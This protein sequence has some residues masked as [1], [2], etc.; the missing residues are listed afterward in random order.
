MI[1]I[2]VICEMAILAL[3]G[4]SAF[5]NVCSGC[6]FAPLHGLSVPVLALL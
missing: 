4:N 1:V 3:R 2:V 5:E 6:L